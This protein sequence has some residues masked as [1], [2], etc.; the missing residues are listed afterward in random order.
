MI[1]PTVLLEVQDKVAAAM[2]KAVTELTGV[3]I[4]RD[5]KR[6]VLAQSE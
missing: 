5:H 1:V 4:N 2:A 3:D 6:V